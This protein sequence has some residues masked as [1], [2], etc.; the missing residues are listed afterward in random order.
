[1]HHLWPDDVHI[2]K[3]PVQDATLDHLIQQFALL[4]GIYKAIDSR[5]LVSLQVYSHPIWYDMK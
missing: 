2:P 4:S 3:Y 1:M 5:I